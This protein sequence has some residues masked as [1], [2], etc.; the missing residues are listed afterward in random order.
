MKARPSDTKRFCGAHSMK[1]SDKRN[2]PFENYTYT[3]LARGYKR[4]FKVLPTMSH[5]VTQ[6]G[7]AC[8]QYVKSMARRGDSKQQVAILGK[9]Y[10]AVWAIYFLFDRSIELDL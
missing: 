6:L 5:I 4:R 10:A 1:L 8:S 2:Q 3:F 7:T 9:N